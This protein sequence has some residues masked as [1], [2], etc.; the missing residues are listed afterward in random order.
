MTTWKLMIE[1]D[2]AAFCGWQTQPGVETVQETLE[3]VVRQIFGGEFI[4]CS[5]SGRTDSGVHALGQVVSFRAET[6][7]D[8]D[9]L[10]MALNTLLPK[11]VSCISASIAPD[12]F[13]ARMAAIGKRYRY[14][15]LHR[16]DRSPFLW[17]RALYVRRPLNWEAI[18]H[19]LVLMRGTYDCSCFRGP[20]CEERNP[21]RS[22]REAFH[23]D[24]GGGEHWIEFE[25][26]GFLRYQIRIMVGTLLEIGEGRRPV[27]DIPRLIASK[28][29]NLSGRT[30]LADGLY[31]VR[32]Y[33][34]EDAALIG[35]LPP[36]PAG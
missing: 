30:A 26:P 36:R 34:P 24:R 29:R 33:Y 35:A 7:R 18:D 28:N 17:T 25:G 22:I 5:A 12:G 1:Y 27:D 14:L 6:Q 10:R 13:H 15:V 20:G 21:I 11:T 9:K 2:G 32:V 4:S 23:V 31:L 3:K 8:P 16:P 19:A